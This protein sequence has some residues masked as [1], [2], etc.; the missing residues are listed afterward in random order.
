MGIG[1]S[2]F[3]T[4]V[5]IMELFK[6]GNV[7]MPAHLFNH[8]QMTFYAGRFPPS[9]TYIQ[10]GAETGTVGLLIL[11]YLYYSIIKYNFF[12]SENYTLFI[13]F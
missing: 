9:N 5:Y 6:G 3:H 8:L 12:I 7:N 11:A 13:F 1:N 10:W 4:P 2:S